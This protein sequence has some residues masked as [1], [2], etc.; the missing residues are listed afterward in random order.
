MSWNG[1]TEAGYVIFVDL[2]AR[3]MIGR[4]MAPPSPLGAEYATLGL[5]V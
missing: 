1:C 3:G 2:R 4:I 5:C